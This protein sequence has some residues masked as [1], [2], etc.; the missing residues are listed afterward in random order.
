[1]SLRGRLA[2]QYPLLTLG[3]P[4]ALR[5]AEPR[6]SGA[7][8]AAKAVL[9]GSRAKERPQVVEPIEQVPDVRR[10]APFPVRV[11]VG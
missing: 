2:S 7:W 1:M 10:G 11:Q 8:P 6:V 3:Q 5:A 9:L 4:G